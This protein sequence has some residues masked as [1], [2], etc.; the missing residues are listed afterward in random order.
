VLA[1]VDVSTVLISNGV[2]VIAERAMWFPGPAMSPMFWTEAHVAAGST[3]TAARWIVA[4]A[5]EGGS[6]N[7]QTFVLVANTSVIDTS[8]RVR[9]LDTSGFVL[10]EGTLRA[11]SRVTLPMR[12]LYDLFGTSDSDFTMGYPGG[13]IV[14]SVGPGAAAAQLVVERSTYWDAAGVT[15]AA[16]TNVLA[17]PVP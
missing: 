6:A 9:R 14:E 2:P 11:N 16:G 1:N 10:Y 5:Y 3:T 4:D 13:V 12:S 17:T 15:W 8:I 7:V